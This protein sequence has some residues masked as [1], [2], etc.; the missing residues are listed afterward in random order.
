M[1]AP[2]VAK[3]ST[4]SRPKQP[5]GPV[6]ALLHR[7]VEDHGLVRSHCQPAVFTQL[8][9]QLTFAPALSS[10]ASPAP[11]LRAG[12][13]WTRLRA[14]PWRWSSPSPPGMVMVEAYSDSSL[15]DRQ[16]L[17][18]LVQHKATLGLHRATLEHRLR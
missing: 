9:F 2:L 11:G 12:A 17:S 8:G 6:V 14:R 16:P 7:R 1:R 10:P 4:T 3:S 13:A 5:Q 18:G 15:A